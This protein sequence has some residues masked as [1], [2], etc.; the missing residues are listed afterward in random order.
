M[1]IF[2]PHIE[3]VQSIRIPDDIKENADSLLDMIEKTIKD[4]ELKKENK[5]QPKKG[6]YLIFYPF[7]KMLSIVV[8]LV[9][10]LYFFTRSM[11][12]AIFCISIHLILEYFMCSITHPQTKFIFYRYR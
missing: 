12:M 3:S 8:V 1:T 4:L 5:E 7:V 10:S 9:L 2:F 6:N 11:N